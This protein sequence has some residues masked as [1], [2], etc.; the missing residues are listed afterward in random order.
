L[1]DN[2]PFL[3]PDTFSVE[4]SEAP[5]VIEAE[6]LQKLGTKQIF[7]VA[8]FQNS[9]RK[10][11]GNR[12]RPR[13]AIPQPKKPRSAPPTP[14]S[15][16]KPSQGGSHKLD[17]EKSPHT[18]SQKKQN[19]QPNSN[20][21]SQLS[22]T[23]KSQTNSKSS[24]PPPGPQTHPISPSWLSKE[25]KKGSDQDG[26]PS[27]SQ[28]VQSKDSFKKVWK[29]FV[30]PMCQGEYDNRDLSSHIDMCLKY[31]SIREVSFAGLNN[32]FSSRSL[33]C[34]LLFLLYREEK[35]REEKRREEKRREEKRKEKQ[36]NFG[37]R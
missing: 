23:P 7:E 29:S 28:A 16:Q 14:P 34:F 2:T 20:P 37:T 8:K 15:S 3:P 4:E 26:G 22:L 31:E 32:S 35:R 10:I 9:L 13:I 33:S 5:S 24:P 11:S 25:G 18:T 12:G 27:S 19:S 6:N 1:D 30:C 17:S 36:K 21:N